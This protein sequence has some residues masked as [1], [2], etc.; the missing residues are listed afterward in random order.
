MTTTDKYDDIINL[1]HHEPRYHSRMSMRQ[2]AAQF[3]P[4]AALK[5]SYESLKETPMDDEEFDDEIS[6]GLM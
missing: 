6:E 3:A 1:P 5:G 2:R 4:F